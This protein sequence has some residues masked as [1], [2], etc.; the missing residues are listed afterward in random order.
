ME[1]DIWIPELSLAF[2]YQG[3]QHYRISNVFESEFLRIQRNDMEKK[4]ACQ[5]HGITLISIPYW[6]DYTISSLA[7]TIRMVII[8]Y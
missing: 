8:P 2:E 6:W 1:L 7:A 3:I 4:K 5:Y